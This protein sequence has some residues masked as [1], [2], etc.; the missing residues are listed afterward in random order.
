MSA[1]SQN[2]HGENSGDL[3]DAAAEMRT[4]MGGVDEFELL[5]TTTTTTNRQHRSSSQQFIYPDTIQQRV[6][7]Q[8]CPVCQLM[9]P[10]GRFGSVCRSNVA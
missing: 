10:K 6:T 8:D 1:A 5:E 3:A 4:Y 7:A 9:L 2:W